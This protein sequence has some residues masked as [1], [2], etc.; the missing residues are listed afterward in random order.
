MKAKIFLGLLV[1]LFLCLSSLY[2]LKK[3]KLNFEKRS[4]YKKESSEKFFFF[5]NQAQVSLILSE[6]KIFFSEIRN[7]ENK[8][9]R[10]YNANY[11]FTNKVKL[12]TALSGKIYMSFDKQTKNL[13]LKK[14]IIRSIIPQRKLRVFYL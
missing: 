14:D 10:I 5:P 7:K 13:Y 6:R 12:L 11:Y 2:L 8:E 3:E 4:E 9:K 1:L